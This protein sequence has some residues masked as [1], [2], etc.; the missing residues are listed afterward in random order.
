MSAASGDTS[1]GPEEPTSFAD[2][3]RSF[4]YGDRADMQDKFPGDP[5][6]PDQRRRGLRGR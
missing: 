5:P 1:E 4:Y 2:F 3:S 6:R